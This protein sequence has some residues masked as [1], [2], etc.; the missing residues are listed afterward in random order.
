M[1]EQFA[2][3]QVLENQVQLAVGLEGVHQLDDERM[4]R[5][6]PEMKNLLFHVETI[7]LC[8]CSG[9]GWNWLVNGARAAV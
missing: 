3:A 1:H 9:W 4:L 2:A 7:F 6:E 8:Y 5:T